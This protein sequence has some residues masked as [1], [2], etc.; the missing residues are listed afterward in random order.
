MMGWK[1]E[2]TPLF[3]TNLEYGYVQLESRSFL[4][5]SIAEDGDQILKEYDPYF[6]FEPSN[7]LWSE[8]RILTL[9]SDRS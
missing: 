5:Q 6:N 8:E 9:E 1:L 2:N 4:L 7:F 3:C